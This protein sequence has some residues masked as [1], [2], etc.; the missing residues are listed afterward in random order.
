M[1][2]KMYNTFLA[3]KDIYTKQRGE[4]V[5]VFSDFLSK[6]SDV[7]ELQIFKR[8]RELAN[9]RQLKNDNINNF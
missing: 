7:D 2:Y 5:K 9:Q 1:R 4:Y 6:F 3:M 8:I